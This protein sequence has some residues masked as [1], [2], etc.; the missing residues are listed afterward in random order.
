MGFTAKSQRHTGRTVASLTFIFSW[1]LL[2][3]SKNICTVCFEV[4]ERSRDSNVNYIT[5]VFVQSP[6]LV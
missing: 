1:D 4:A 3:A 2:T 6:T 5:A